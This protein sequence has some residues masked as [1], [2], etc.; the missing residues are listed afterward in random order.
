M[1][2]VKIK[3][4]GEI[5]DA[6][7]LSPQYISSGSS[8]SDDDSEIE[9]METD[10][11]HQSHLGQA[12]SSLRHLLLPTTSKRPVDCLDSS[13][14]PSNKRSKGKFF[15]ARCELLTMNTTD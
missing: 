4:E 1:E 8:E 14:N 10:S 2:S 12:H 5:K 11:N 3:A 15:Y 6:K 7:A 13:N 9:T